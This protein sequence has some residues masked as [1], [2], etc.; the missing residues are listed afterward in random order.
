VGCRYISVDA[1]NQPG[2]IAFYENNN[3]N[4]IK[5][6][7]EEETVLMYRDIIESD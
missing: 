7:K 4:M 1:Y 6:I 3:F 5:P 2:V